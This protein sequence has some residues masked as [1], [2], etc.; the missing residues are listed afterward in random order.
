MK[1]ADF[2]GDERD[3]NGSYLFGAPAASLVFTI[4]LIDAKIACIAG[5][6]KAL[7]Y[8]SSM[9]LLAIYMQVY[10][11]LPHSVLGASFWHVPPGVGPFW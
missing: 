1:I 6:N 5:V 4:A 11:I 7:A 2:V 3:G 10:Y 9:G 8:A